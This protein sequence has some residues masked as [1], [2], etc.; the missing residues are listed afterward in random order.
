MIIRINPNPD[1]AG[2]DKI[3]EEQD[4][5]YGRNRPDASTPPTVQQCEESL[6][7]AIPGDQD[8]PRTPETE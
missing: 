1:Y 2:L 6:L 8:R 7:S 4:R 3:I 5:Y